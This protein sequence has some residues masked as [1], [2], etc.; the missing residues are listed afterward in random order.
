MSELGSTPTGAEWCLKA[1]HPSDPSVEVRGI[2]DNS[3]VP[4]TFI[5]Y[6]SVLTLSP[7]IGAEGTWSFDLN[8][9]P[10]PICPASHTQTDSVGLSY[11]T[12]LNQQLG[13]GT[14]RQKLNIFANDVV[15]WR[16]AYMSVS[17]HQDGPDLANQG[18][19]VAVQK[20]CMPEIAY[21][22]KWEDGFGPGCAYARKL[23]AYEGLDYPSY[24]SAM[25]MPN[26]YF[27]QSKYGCYM[28]LKLT[29]T[30]QQWKSVGR[31]RSFV[32]GAS[33]PFTCV[34]NSA[35]MPTGATSA[36]NRFPYYDLYGVSGENGVIL[37]DTT[38]DFGNETIGQ[39]SAQNLSVQSSFTFH[40][41]MGIEVQV[42]PASPLSPY[43]R[44][45]PPRD[46]TAIATYFAIARE[47]KD[48]YP[49]DFND[50]GK[51]WDVISGALTTVAPLISLVPHPIAQAAAT[52]IPMAVRGINAVVARNKARKLAKSAK[53]RG[54]PS[55]AQLE[56]DRA[57]VSRAL[58][59]RQITAA[60]RRVARR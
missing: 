10:D 29:K 9:L 38:L 26:A 31:D 59:A 1:L 50:L 33:T 15:R 55:Q 25:A 35:L 37:G 23:A 51:L 14:Y 54:D 53:G 60:K 28:P 39:I 11:A 3:A 2:P 56:R 46:K 16:L 19:L 41:R 34:D 7:Q 45:S 13:G 48:G 6:Q 20:S 18:T 4:S 58:T 8:M 40:F 21:P 30:C 57:Q 44:L 12:F 52:G 5:N 27:N 47:L 36:A 43:L 32:A 17:A 49:V 24:E 22:Y 42:L